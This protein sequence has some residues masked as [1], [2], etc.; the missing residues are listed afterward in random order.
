MERPAE[1]RP[2]WAATLKHVGVYYEGLVDDAESIV[3][4]CKLESVTTF[5]V[6]TSRGNSSQLHSRMHCVSPEIKQRVRRR[7]RFLLY[8]YK[9]CNYIVIIINL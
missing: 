3:E 2:E 9:L 1:E 7:T 4:H 6:R 8:S 5:G